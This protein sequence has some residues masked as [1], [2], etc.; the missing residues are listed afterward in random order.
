LEVCVGVVR[1]YLRIESAAKAKTFGIDS[2]CMFEVIN[3]KFNTILS[4]VQ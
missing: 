4:P 2:P 1:Q 3:A